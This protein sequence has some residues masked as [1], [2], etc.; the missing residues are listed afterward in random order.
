MHN[1]SFRRSGPRAVCALLL[2][3]A[4]AGLASAQL[5]GLGGLGDKL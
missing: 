2:L 3:A 5:G 1:S 4:C